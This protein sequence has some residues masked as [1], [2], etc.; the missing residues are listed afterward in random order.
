MTDRELHDELIKYLTDPQ[1]RAQGMPALG[2]DDEQA[3]RAGKFA[4]FLARRYYRD[5]VLR[6]FRYATLLAAPGEP[7]AA[8]A[9]E[10]PQFQTI[11]DESV[12][13][14]CAAAQR[15]G[16]IVVAQLT[17]IANIPSWR[18]SLA[19]YEYAH[20][21]QTATAEQRTPAVYRQQNVSALCVAFDWHMPSL[22][23]RIRT[24][25]AVTEDLRRLVTLLF[26][27]THAGK[28]YVMEIDSPTASVFSAVNSQR[29]LREIAWE[30]KTEIESTGEILNSLAEVGAIIPGA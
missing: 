24:G 20:F 11:V 26:S 27:R 14:S 13:G 8:D 1:L 18:R 9:I 25:V 30:A 4:L 19:D 10:S 28:I 16:R 5:R 21:L 6:S 15:I 17:A 23:Q 12:M 29:T 22:L 3:E 2:L 7:L